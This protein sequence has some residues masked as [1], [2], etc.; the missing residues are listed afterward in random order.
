[1]MEI[2]PYCQELKQEILKNEWIHVEVELMHKISDDDSIENPYLSVGNPQ[3]G[4]HVFKEK[5]TMEADVIFSNPYR[6]R[7]SDDYQNDLFLL[8]SQLRPLKKQRTC[9]E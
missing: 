7:K 3:M 4:I 2:F 9:V 8:D 6:K 5:E 1:M